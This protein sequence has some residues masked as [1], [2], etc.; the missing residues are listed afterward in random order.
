MATESL[1]LYLVGY[2]C[3]GKSRAGRLVA[4]RLRWRFADSDQEVERQAGRAIDQIVAGEGW[5]GFRK[6][7][8]VALRQLCL[9]CD[10]VVATGGGVV[11]NSENVDDMRRTGRVVWLRAEIETIAARMQADAQRA[12]QRPSLTGQSAVAEIESVLAERK[13][14]YQAAADFVVETDCLSLL[15]VADRV[16]DWFNQHHMKS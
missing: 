15:D 10:T 5:P 2:R 13:T 6:R 9:H 8:R 3:T 11:L 1:N 4:G 12:S 16:V 14:L 7:E